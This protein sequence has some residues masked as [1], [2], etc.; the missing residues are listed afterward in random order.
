MGSINLYKLDDNKVPEF[1]RE[2]GKYESRPPKS[3]KVLID[4]EEKEY[5]FQLFIYESQEKKAVSW[6]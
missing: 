6:N 4:G 1:L 3:Q 2:L 5:E